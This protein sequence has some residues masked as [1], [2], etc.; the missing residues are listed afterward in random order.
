M[1]Y[2]PDARGKGSLKMAAEVETFWTM[3]LKSARA[4]SFAEVSSCGA[5]S[6]ARVR[7]SKLRR[8]NS[9]IWKN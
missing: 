5:H 3:R 2:R 8:S 7:H 4:I 1:A 9:A 6:F